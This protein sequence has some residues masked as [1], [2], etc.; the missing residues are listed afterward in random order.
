MFGR[1]GHF[2]SVDVVAGRGVELPH[3]ESHDCRTPLIHSDTEHLP[4]ENAA[5]LNR[6]RELNLRR[7]IERRLQTGL[8][9]DGFFDASARHDFV[10]ARTLKFNGQ[11]VGGFAAQKRVEARANGEIRQVTVV[12]RDERKLAQARQLMTQGTKLRQR[13]LTLMQAA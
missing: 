1:F 12:L 9:R 10:F 8:L 5:R 7:I 3:F 11:A 13:V 2:G 4:G 6:L